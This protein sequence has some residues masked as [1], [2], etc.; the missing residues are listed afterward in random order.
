M[1]S[2]NCD[3]I[4]K[5]S[6]N[7][8]DLSSELRNEILTSKSDSTSCLLNCGNHGVCDLINL[9]C[10]CNPDFKGKNCEM[11]TDPCSSQPCLNDGIC[12]HLNSNSL[13]SEI[14]RRNYTCNCS[15]LFYG[16]NCEWK[17]NVCGSENCNQ[18]GYCIDN[19][20]I[21]SCIC[22]KGYSGKKCEG[23]T[24]DVITAKTVR[25]SS[26]IITIL[27]VVL[28]IFYIISIDLTSLK[29]KEFGLRT[30]KIKI[31]ISKK[32]IKKI[33]INY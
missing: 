20:S 1:K 23:A 30:E 9:K 15:K 17:I 8:Q 22:V 3:T 31:T 12:H 26:M 25:T 21:P 11:E 4:L 10:K 19:S 29:L 28:F 2:S 16:R 32:R 6:N 27:A 7:L 24:Q 5:Y 33:H 14:N 13:Y 18:H